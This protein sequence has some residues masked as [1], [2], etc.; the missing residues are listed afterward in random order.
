MFSIERPSRSVNQSWHRI[1]RSPCPRQ[2]HLPR[3][4]P[5]K[6]VVTTVLFALTS[7]FHHFG[8]PVKMLRL[9]NMRSIDATAWYALTTGSSLC[10]RSSW[11]SI[12]W[13]IKD[14]D[15]TKLQNKKYER[16][17]SFTAV[18]IAYVNWLNSSS[19][20]KFEVFRGFTSRSGGYYLINFVFS[21][22]WKWNSH[23]IPQWHYNP[24]KKCASLLRPCQEKFEWLTVPANFVWKA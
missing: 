3:P 1:A 8:M 14:I 17:N 18:L 22:I 6:L 4:K 15:L 23:Q 12:G 11:V 21:Y 19:E 20:E 24:H 10:V 7:S 13:M 5:T 16:W 2:S 9:G